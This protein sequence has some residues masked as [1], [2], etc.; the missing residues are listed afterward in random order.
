MLGSPRSGTTW[1]AALLSSLTGA[2]LIDEPLIGVHLSVPVA[3]V[4]SLPDAEDRLVLDANGSR[5]AY[6][7]SQA[8]SAAWTPAL[9]SLLLRRFAAQAPWRG[10]VVVKEPNGA[11]AAPVLLRTL[12]RSRL[13][14]VVRDGRDVVDSLLDG[15]SGGWISS[16]HGVAL[17]DGGR[18]AFIERRA[19]HWVA[20]V[21]AVQDAYLAH[22]PDR[23]LRVTYEDLRAD[24][25]TEVRRI[26][27]WLG[28]GDVADIDTTV[29]RLSFEALPEG[30]KGTGRFAR[31][32]TPGLW[33]ERF[34]ADEQALL[35]RVMGATLE[36]LGY[37]RARAR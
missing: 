23:R 11:R 27:E 13:L 34:A 15:A 14:F 20:T 6:F 7:F 12:P 35:D 32:A 31:A 29:D 18:R 36:E 9:R 2:A 3:A 28:R 4:T 16:T 17:G 26:L 22:S 30:D 37:H 25:T 8:T 33:R 19:E 24:T 5:P 10:L 1:L 21:R